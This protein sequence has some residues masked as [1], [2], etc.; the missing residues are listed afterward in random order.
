MRS[1]ATKVSQPPEFEGGP[2]PCMITDVVKVGKLT[3]DLITFYPDPSA[4]AVLQIK[5]LFEIGPVLRPFLATKSRRILQFSAKIC[6]K[7]TEKMGF[8][9][10]VLLKRV[11]SCGSRQSVT[12]T[13]FVFAKESTTERNR[14]T[15]QPDGRNENKTPTQSGSADC[16]RRSL[17]QKH[18]VT[19]GMG[20]LNL[21]DSQTMFPERPQRGAQ[22]SR[23]RSPSADRPLVARSSPFS[24]RV[25][26]DLRVGVFFLRAR[27]ISGKSGAR[28][29]MR[30]QSIDST[31]VASQIPRPNK[32]RHAEFKGLTSH[33]SGKRRTTSSGFV[34]RL[35]RGGIYL[36]IPQW[37]LA[38]FLGRA[39]EGLLNLKDLLAAFPPRCR[40]T[41][42]GFV[43]LSKRAEA[44]LLIPQGL[45]AK[46]LRRT[47]E[48]L[49]SLKDLLTAFE[50]GLNGLFESDPVL[51]PTYL[52]RIGPNSAIFQQKR[53][54]NRRKWGALRDRLRTC[55]GLRLVSLH[56]RCWRDYWLEN[57]K[58]D[59]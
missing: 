26:C 50:P 24:P 13:Y 43:E 57:L 35:R 48:G 5:G 59:G 34:G 4:G 17:T 27:T 37:L 31:M 3:K 21:K 8:S 7:T 32:E 22:R 55:R 14:G 30:V 47:G 29:S 33:A 51:R 58:A 49:L 41:S 19:L 11:K 46:L 44:Y 28:E 18:R 6:K 56:G 1:T 9:L 45:L 53:A 2:A 54:D 38:E 12:G 39:K 52:F 23:R 20:L 25:V 42:S 10:P 15:A 16:R 36:L 40:A